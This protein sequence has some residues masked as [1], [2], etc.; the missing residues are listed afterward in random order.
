MDEIVKRIENEKEN[1]VKKYSST[2]QCTV[3]NA[4]CKV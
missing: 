3:H 1:F 4:E 2:A